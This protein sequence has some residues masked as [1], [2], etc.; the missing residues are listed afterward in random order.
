[1]IVYL[2]GCERDRRG[3]VLMEL[4]KAGDCYEPQLKRL[5]RNVLRQRYTDGVIDEMLAPERVSYED[6]ARASSDTSST[7]PPSILK[8]IFHEHV[9]KR[10]PHR[11]VARERRA[12]CRNRGQGGDPRADEARAIEARAGA[13]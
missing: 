6:L 4:E 12:R 9:R 5:A 7:E 2:P 10:G 11:G 1:M 8:S 13:S 3:S